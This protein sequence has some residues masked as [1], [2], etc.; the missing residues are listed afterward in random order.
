M[1]PFG[2]TLAPR[3]TS[4]IIGSSS[5][6]GTPLGAASPVPP[7][8]HLHPEGSGIPNNPPSSVVNIGGF[9]HA[10]SESDNRQP[11]LPMMEFPQ[12]DG[13]VVRVW[14]DKCSTY[15]H[16]Y[17]IPLD[18]RVIAESLHMIDRAANWFQVYKHSTGVHSWE[19]FVISVSR[20]FEEN[21]H[22]VKIRELL[23][24]K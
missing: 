2:S 17:G 1:R 9:P 15:F 6:L 10:G 5:S 7:S 11:W 3:M 13:F 19:H 23:H 22:R 18:F 20:E 14:L 24:L 16:L 8:Q 12:F 21:T 4:G